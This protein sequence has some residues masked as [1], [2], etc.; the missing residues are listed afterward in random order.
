[1]PFSNRV[2]TLINFKFQSIQTYEP[3]IICLDLSEI[4]LLPGKVQ[5]VYK[6]CGHIDI[7]INN[8]GISNRGNI[9]DTSME[10]QKRLMYVNHFGPAA[11]TEGMLRCQ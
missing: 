4:D 5:D 3:I 8:G 6:V 11:L 1:M 9:L 10:V 7:L 2:V